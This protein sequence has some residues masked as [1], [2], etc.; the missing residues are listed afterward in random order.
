MGH[1]ELFDITT[2]S[3]Y[4]KSTASSRK[5]SPSLP[6]QLG[7]ILVRSSNSNKSKTQLPTQFKEWTTFH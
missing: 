1:Q 6:T 3:D 4:R 5:R 7:R 2:Q